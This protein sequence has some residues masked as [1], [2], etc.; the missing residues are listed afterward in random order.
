VV[1]VIVLALAVLAAATPADEMLQDFV[2]RHF[3]SHEVRLLANGFTLLGTTEVAG[4]GMLALAA[5]AY[6]AGDAE[7]WQAATGGVIGVLLAGLTTQVVKNVACRARPRLIDGWGVGAPVPPDDPARRGFFHWPC[8]G[9][10][11]YNGFPSGHAATAFA[12]ASSLL[13]WAPPRRRGWILAAASGVGISRIVLN[14][15][16]LSDVLGGG[17]F[18][19]WAG[20][21]GVAIATRY[22]MPRWR[23]RMAG[24]VP[25]SRTAA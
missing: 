10:G 8:F 11:D 3:V 22:V 20:E 25:R 23:A 4:V 14:A 7:M 18:G 21:A 13:V 16:F 2:F 17:L 12:V 5:V 9:E 24:P 15:H 6:R 19:W 1:Q